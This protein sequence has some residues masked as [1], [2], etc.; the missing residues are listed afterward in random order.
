MMAKKLEEALYKHAP[1]KE[2]YAD[3]STLEDR[4]EDLAQ[5]VQVQAA[6]LKLKKEQQQQQE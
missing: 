6:V 2:L 1:S 3:L 4:L 5:K